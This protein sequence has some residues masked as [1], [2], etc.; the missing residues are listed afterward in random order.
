ME[1]KTDINLSIEDK[2]KSKV[3]KKEIEVKKL[4]LVEY[5]Q[6]IQYEEY[7]KLMESTFEGSSNNEDILP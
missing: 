3:R 5:K 4:Q 2:S 1:E 6:L 7:A